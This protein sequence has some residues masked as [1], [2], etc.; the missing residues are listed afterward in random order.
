MMAIGAEAPIELLTA[1]G[2]VRI[3]LSEDR[4]VVLKVESQDENGRFQLSDNFKVDIESCSAGCF[5]IRLKN[6]VTAAG[7]YTCCITINGRLRCT[8]IAIGTPCP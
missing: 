2:P 3:F 6:T 7:T 5:K 4:R 8:E 1:E